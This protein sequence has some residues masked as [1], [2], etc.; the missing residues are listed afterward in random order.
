VACDM[1]F[2]NPALIRHLLEQPGDV[3]LPAG[4]RGPEP[5]HAIY[6]RA[7]LPAIEAAAAVGDWKMTGFHKDVRV[8]RVDVDEKAWLVEGRSPFTNANTPD[9]WSALGGP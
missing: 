8:T 6:A 2:L 9:E 5:L 3:V 7:C 1:P 4:S